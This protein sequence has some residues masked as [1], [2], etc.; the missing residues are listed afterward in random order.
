[1][2]AGV[3]GGFLALFVLQPLAD[4]Y[5]PT[6]DQVRDFF[7]NAW[8]WLNGPEVG[9]WIFIMICGGVL[10]VAWRNMRAS[11]WSGLAVCVG[12]G[13]A[14][15]L[16]YRVMNGYPVGAAPTMDP[17]AWI[18]AA[19]FLLWL[20]LAV[21]IPSAH[22]AVV[23]LVASELADRDWRW[24]LRK[25]EGIDAERGAR[26][27]KRH[28]CNVP[29]HR[30]MKGYET[31]NHELRSAR[32]RSLRERWRMSGELDQEFKHPGSPDYDAAVVRSDLEPVLSWTE[33]E[34]LKPKRN[35]VDDLRQ[36]A[37]PSAL[38]DTAE[39]GEPTASAEGL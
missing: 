3:I 14:G 2:L 35:W 34:S 28:T 8:N 26:L 16:A 31:C 11:R 21:L 24:I 10:Y 36:I 1:M 37:G 32:S 39:D 9:L 7:G 30:P 5:K 20:V 38:A 12:L 22:R 27:D 33:L 25:R 6:G 29:K 13:V 23:D 17:A 19:G 4:A 18:I 15:G